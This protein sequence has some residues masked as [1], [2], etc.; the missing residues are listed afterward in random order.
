MFGL[1]RKRHDFDVFETQFDGFGPTE[2]YDPYLE[3]RLRL[4][5][6]FDLSCEC[7]KWTRHNPHCVTQSKGLMF[8][9]G[10]ASLGFLV[11]VRFSVSILFDPRN[12]V[13]NDVLGNVARSSIVCITGRT[14]SFEKQ[15]IEFW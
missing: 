8:F 15:M 5:N 6:A 11:H 12:D 13:I 2:N 9:P 4:V 10:Y 1:S 14:R 3:K 7:G